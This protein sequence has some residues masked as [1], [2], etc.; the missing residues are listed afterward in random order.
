MKKLLFFIVC[1]SAITLQ[2]QE[3]ERILVE[4]K[5]SAPADSDIEGVSLYNNSSNKG[6]ITD[7]NGEFKLAVALHDEIVVS[8]IQ[9]ATFK[10]SVDQ[11]TITK[12]ELGIY[13][14]PVVNKLTEVTVRK[15]DL[16]GNLIV[17]VSNI[18]TVDFATEFDTSFE[19]VEFDYVFRPDK[20]SSIPGNFAEDAFYNGQQP[21]NSAN[22]LGGL[23]LL[24]QLLW[25][26]KASKSYTIKLRDPEKIVSAIR[27]R[28][29]YEDIRTSFNIPEGKEDDFLYFTEENG[30]TN[31]LLLE[32]NQL[33]LLSLLEENAIAYRNQIDE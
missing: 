10:V 3:V 21:Y 23:G 33:I 22:L 19:T 32:K 17:D 4:G 28:F 20:W 9:Y 1:I 8:A 13:L 25:N 30:L 6:V 15:Y 26:K 7:K 18:K 24:S 2:A 16:T 14:N 12:K 5:I 27:E 11:R 31:D 29:S